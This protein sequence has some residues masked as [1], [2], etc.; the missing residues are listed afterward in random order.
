MQLKGRWYEDEIRMLSESFKVPIFYLSEALGMHKD[1]D[2]IIG[3]AR[4]G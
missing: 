3:L 1:I 4:P 2:G